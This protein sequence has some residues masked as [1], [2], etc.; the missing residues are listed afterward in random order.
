MTE[1]SFIERK[2]QTDKSG[3]L[4][5]VVAFANSTPIGLPAVLFI[6]VSDDGVISASVDVERTM[7]A[8]S[9]YVAAH[10]WPP[11][12]TLPRA[13]TSQ[14]NSCVAVIVPGSAER[15]HFAGRSFVRVGTQTK[16]ASDEQFAALVASRSSKARAIQDWIGKDI[17]WMNRNGALGDTFASGR[18]TVEGCNSHFATFAMRADGGYLDLY[19]EP[20]SRLEISFDHKQQRLQ[21]IRYGTR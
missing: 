18:T 13:L 8:F 2:S 14:G 20:L 1:D 21:I 4:K 16:E 3:W 9:D 17:S 10:A 6:G 12:F 19:S 11:I 15:P 5:T 7:Q